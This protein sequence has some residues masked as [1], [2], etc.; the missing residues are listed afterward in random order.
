MIPTDPFNRSVHAR[1]DR[2]P[3][4][5]QRVEFTPTEVGP[6]V[7]SILYGG[8]PVRGSPHTTMAYDASRVRIVDV[9]QDGA[10]GQDHGF[11]GM[12]SHC[13]QMK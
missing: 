7:V 2:L 4:G 6:H 10:I 8:Q 5:L 11:T 1:V 13:K 12:T 3:D 9:T